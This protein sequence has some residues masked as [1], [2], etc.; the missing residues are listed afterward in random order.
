MTTFLEGILAAHRQ[1]AAADERQLGILLDAA[2]GVPGPAR[3]FEPA[4]AEAGGISVIAEIKRRSPS[5]G[6]LYQGLDPAEL[7]LSYQC[8]GAACVS[9]LTDDQFFGGSPADL[10]AVSRAC[11]LPVLRKDFTVCPA[12]VCD[13]RLMGADAVLL[14]VAALG[15][16][17]LCGLAELAASLGM[18][19]LVEVHDETE[20]AMALDAGATMVGVNQR[21]LATFEVD[22]D[23]AAKLRPL[24]PEGVVAVAES[25][26]R[27]PADAERLR[28]AG[29][30]AILVGESLVT[31]SD[32][33][34]AV[35][36]LVHAGRN[37]SLSPGGLAPGRGAV[38]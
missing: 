4:L 36:A 9:V 19:A 23:R 12:D 6:A 7:A 27:S 2:R 8:G 33:A 35:A 38:V 34:A 20:L 14:I 29:Y 15:Q 16:G 28:S 13:A 11:G 18:S 32:P 26:I 24:I 3:P 17:E 25:G 30:D 21:D 31:A 10:V 1:A 5:R 22:P 37:G